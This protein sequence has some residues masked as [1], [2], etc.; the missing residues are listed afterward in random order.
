[1]LEL[2]GT[3]GT[4][5]ARAKQIINDKVKPSQKG[6]LGAGFYLWRYDPYA[7]ILAI[8]WC[9]QLKDSGEFS[10]DAEQECVAL[11]VG[12]CVDEDEFL[13][14][15]SGEL[16]DILAK[17]IAGK[18]KMNFDEQSK[19]FDEFIFDLEQE[20]GSKIALVQYRVPPP[21][22]KYCPDY[23]KRFLGRPICYIVKDTNIVKELRFLEE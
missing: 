3:H 8:G 9:E 11:I 22:E 6:L 19:F 21:K 1:M 20:M 7:K 12:L 2:K 5:L 18:D 10:G 23:P 17:A 4:S 13:P 14:L 15:D 16:R